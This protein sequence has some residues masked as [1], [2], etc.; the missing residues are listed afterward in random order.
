MRPSD[1]TTS[2]SARFR[3]TFNTCS[4]FACLLESCDRHLTEA[5]QQ[6]RETFVAVG[7]EST[8]QN[9]RFC[10]DDA[11]PAR[12]YIFTYFPS[13]QTLEPSP[14]HS[15]WPVELLRFPA[16]PLFLAATSSSS[17]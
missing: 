7:S 5:T 9:K 12:L 3:W 8:A 13:V 6:E 2:V 11:A 14:T 15:R 10:L 16:L 1:L 17:A 4:R